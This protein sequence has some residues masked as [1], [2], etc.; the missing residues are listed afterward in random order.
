[1]ATITI[2]LTEEQQK[3]LNEGNDITI[4]SHSVAK[5]SIDYKNLEYP[6]GKT[7]I[8]GSIC[9]SS[10]NYGNS[11]THK[12]FGIYRKFRENAERDFALKTQSLKLGALVEAVQEELDDKFE[13]DWENKG[14]E[15]YYIDY[16]YRKKSFSVVAS[17]TYLRASIGVLYMSKQVA[18]RVVKIL[19]ANP[20]II[21]D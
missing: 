6:C 18:D 10:E 9:V 20:S 1:M 8:I 3:A 7:F 5:S 17:Y 16:F 2:E 13:P 21:F 15:K 4:T 19:D 11:T 14:Q 12:D